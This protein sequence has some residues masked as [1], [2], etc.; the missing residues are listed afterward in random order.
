M[1][2]YKKFMGREPDVEALLE[3]DGLLENT[4]A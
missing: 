4:K 1:E 3:R 2:L